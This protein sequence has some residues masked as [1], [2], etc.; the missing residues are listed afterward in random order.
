ME[1]Q[2]QAY[3]AVTGRVASYIVKEVEEYLDILL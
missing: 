3:K 2:L 1:I